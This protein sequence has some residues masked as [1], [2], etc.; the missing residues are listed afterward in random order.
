MNRAARAAA[1]IF[2][3]SIASVAL[4]QPGAPG[5]PEPA[6]LRGDSAQTRKRLTEL[7]THAARAE[8]APD[9][10]SLRR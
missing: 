3:L 9:S 8:L 1:C 10:P 6:N 5:A 4:A 2:V 7:A